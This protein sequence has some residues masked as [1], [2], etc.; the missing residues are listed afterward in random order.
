M[1]IEWN[2][3]I[4]DKSKLESKSNSTCKPKS[5]KSKTEA[6]RN[7]VSEIAKTINNVPVDTDLN[8]GRVKVK[9]LAI[10]PVKP[11]INRIK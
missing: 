11:R 9:R 7:K 5:I 8:L 10:L 4:K 6:N 3:W 2:L 1:S